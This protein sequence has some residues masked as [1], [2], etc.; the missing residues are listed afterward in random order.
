MK[1]EIK[2]YQFAVHNI[3]NVRK[4]ELVRIFDR[5]N[6]FGFKPLVFW[7]LGRWTEPKPNV[8]F[9]EILPRLDRYGF[10]GS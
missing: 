8:W 3:V 7:M 4:S 10:L 6:W 2:K 5:S 9:S 1:R